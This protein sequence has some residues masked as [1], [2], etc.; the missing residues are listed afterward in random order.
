MQGPISHIV[1]RIMICMHVKH[2]VNTSAGVTT[3][4]AVQSTAT[5][6]MQ[7]VSYTVVM[8]YRQ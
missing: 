4:R 5:A 1:E 2:N 3:E 8:N 7:C 6:V